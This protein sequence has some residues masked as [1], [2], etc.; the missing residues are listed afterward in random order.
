MPTRRPAPLAPALLLPAVHC[1]QRTAVWSYKHAACVIN[2]HCGLQKC[3]NL[4]ALL[5]RSTCS[6][7]YSCSQTLRTNKHLHSCASYASAGARGSGGGA[8]RPR[9]PHTMNA[10][11]ASAAAVVAAHAPMKHPVAPMPRC[12]VRSD[13][14][15]ASVLDPARATPGGGWWKWGRHLTAVSSEPCSR[16]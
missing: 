10:S 9:S 16:W 13:R 14:R 8:S 11:R 6:Y 5:N 15:P 4:G 1:L 7:S 3:S 2:M 12:K